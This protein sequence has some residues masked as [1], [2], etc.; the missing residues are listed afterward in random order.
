MALNY[1]KNIKYYLISIGISLIITVLLLFKNILLM[2]LNEYG[3][4]GI[5]GFC[6]V[7]FSVMTLVYIVTFSLGLLIYSII[8]KA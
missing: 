4:W 1:L 6:L 3:I 2:G 7:F 8:K 5:L